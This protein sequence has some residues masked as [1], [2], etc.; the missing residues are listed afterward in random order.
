MLVVLVVVSLVLFLALPRLAKPTEDERLKDT[1]RRLAALAREA[2]SQAVSSARPH[3]VCLDMGGR[4]AWLS[5]VRPGTEGDAGRAGRDIV[6]P[7]DVVLV[8]VVH[9]TD[10]VVTGGRPSFGFWPQGGNEPGL[11]HLK[12]EKG[13]QRTLQ[14]LPY[15]GRTDIHEGYWREETTQ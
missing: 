9:P 8:D 6:W 14:I 13:T 5:L 1:A 4:R 3:F 2:H 12:N 7:E 10:G 11:I 15:L